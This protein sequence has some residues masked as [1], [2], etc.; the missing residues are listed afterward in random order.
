[1]GNIT[2]ENWPRDER[3]RAYRRAYK[4][5]TGGGRKGRASEMRGSEPVHEARKDAINQTIKAL[6][7]QRDMLTRAS[8]KVVETCGYEQ[9]AS[10][11]SALSMA[12]VNVCRAILMSVGDSAPD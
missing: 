4:A 5:S 3:M 2:T 12:Q 9:L 11:L 7:A 10:A 8:E 6:E 1:M